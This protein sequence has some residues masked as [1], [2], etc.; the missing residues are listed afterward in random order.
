MSSRKH[1]LKFRIKASIEA[2]KIVRNNL[3]LAY[4][5]LKQLKKDAVN[6]TGDRKEYMDILIS[7]LSYKLEQKENSIYESEIGYIDNE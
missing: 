2:S 3:N 7:M 6:L 4:D 5:K 1:N